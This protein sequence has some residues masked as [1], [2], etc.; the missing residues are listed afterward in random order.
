MLYYSVLGSKKVKE[1]LEEY[2]RIFRDE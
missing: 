2:G 1:L